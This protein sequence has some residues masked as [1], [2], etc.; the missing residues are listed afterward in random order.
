M[1]KSDQEMESEQDSQYFSTYGETFSQQ[2]F[3]NRN[4]QQVLVDTEYFAKQMND[5]MTQQ[6]NMVKI[7]K[8]NFMLKKKVHRD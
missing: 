4:E 7:S 1:N 6:I 8:W 5:L 2:T 3:G